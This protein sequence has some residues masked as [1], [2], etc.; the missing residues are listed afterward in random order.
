MSE[1]KILHDST[2]CVYN[3]CELSVSNVRAILELGDGYA[4][5]DTEQGKLIVEGEN[6]KIESFVKEDRRVNVV[7]KFDSIYYSKE[8]TISKIFGKTRQ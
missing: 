7:G 8:K 3:R 4:A 2:I 5:F 1:E 6:I